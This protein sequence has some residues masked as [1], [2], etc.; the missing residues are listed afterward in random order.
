MVRSNRYTQPTNSVLLS[1]TKTHQHAQQIPVYCDNQIVSHVMY[2]HDMLNIPGKNK[3][4]TNSGGS[5]AY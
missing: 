3:N 1:K 4:I 5:D 2:S